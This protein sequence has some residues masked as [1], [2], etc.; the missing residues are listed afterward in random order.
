M[1]VTELRKAVVDRA[2][3]GPGK[4]AEEQRQAA[5]DNEGVAPA[6]RGLVDKIAKHA[7]KVT[8]DDIA[9]ARAAGIS[10]DE[11]FELA[12]CAALGQASRQLDAALAAVDAAT[13][14]A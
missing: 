3:T 12:V 13:R 10:E 4:A 9:A 8:D 14:T 5:F 7:Y 2:R 6:V 11:I 1:N